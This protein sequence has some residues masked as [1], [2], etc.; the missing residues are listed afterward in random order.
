MRE[1]WQAQHHL[2]PMQTTHAQTIINTTFNI[3]DLFNRSVPENIIS[4]TCVVDL[5]HLFDP[6]HLGAMLC[7]SAS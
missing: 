2:R 5:F 3:I 4:K 7:L 1:E 6:A